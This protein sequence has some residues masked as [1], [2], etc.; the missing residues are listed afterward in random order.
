M[1]VLVTGGSGMLGS[2]LVEQL[3][4]RGHEVDAPSREALDITDPMSVANVT[5]DE[6]KGT[7]WCINC[8][9]YTAV[10]NA[11]TE[12]REATELNAIGP[13]YLAR[14]CAMA[15]IP[16]VHISTDFVFDGEASQ[17]YAEDDRTNP[18]GAYGRTKLAGETAV[19]GSS[20]NSMVVRTSWLYGPNG[21]SFPR[22]MIAAWEAGKT[23]SVVAD[24]VGNPTYTGDLARTLVDFVEKNPY[25]GIYHATGPDTMSWHDLA[26][27]TLETYNELTG[28]HRAVEVEPIRTED[29][30]TPARRPKY[31]ALSNARV[32]E[33]GISPMRP[34]AEAMKDFCQRLATG[35][36]E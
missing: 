4:A 13:G 7:R 2:D 20:P 3:R 24:Q 1:R 28:G 26:T 9:A 17:P 31:S 35:N 14:A 25:P 23:L 34:T 32:Q 33:L 22:T 30:P 21:K 16:L 8:A 19:L 6:Y 10:D 15:M 11:E 29:W 5:A 27:L 18:Q 36:A 12:I